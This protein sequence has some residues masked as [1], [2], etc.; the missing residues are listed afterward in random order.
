MNKKEYSNYVNM[1]VTSQ[2]MTHAINNWL[3]NNKPDIHVRIGNNSR[4]DCDGKFCRFVFDCK[5][6]PEDK[7]L[8]DVIGSAETKSEVQGQDE[9]KGTI[10]RILIGDFLRGFISKEEFKHLYHRY[11]LDFK[12][13]ENENS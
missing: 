3:D 6:L 7:T 5:G 13:H 10:A 11:H 8:V 9:V 12:E 1:L 4:I 2:F